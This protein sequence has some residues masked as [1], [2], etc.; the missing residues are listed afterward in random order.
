MMRSGK[1]SPD[2][3]RRLVLGKL[4]TRRAD[5]L[6][7][8]ALGEDSAVIDFG[9]ESCVLSADPITA[10]GERA[11]W[12]GVHVACN[13]IAAMGAAPVG[14]LA[15]VLLPES[16]DE[17]LVS[18]VMND[19]HRAATELGI[20]ILGGHTEVT[21]GIAAPILAMTAVGKAP[22]DRIVRSSG[23]RVG[24]AIVLAKWAGLEGT[25]ILSN[26]C[27]DDLTGRV[28]PALIAAGARC[29]DF[30][31][32]VRE[33]LAAAALGATAMHDPTEGGVLGAMW[34]MAES[35]GLGFELD[36]ERV[37]IREETQAICE[38]FGADPLKLISSGA[39]LIACSDGPA[40]VEGLQA[41]SLT[42]TVIGRM[43]GA[44]RVVLCGGCRE[45]AEPVWRD[46][47]WRVL[48]ERSG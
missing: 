21:P 26:D 31:S 25:A 13:D 14:V 23:A 32:V 38:V 37:P 11:G 3:L 24:D 35:S 34:E 16:A 22:R 8:A 10:A 46:E 48:D 4:G 5:V 43:Q 6:V 1:L 33:G 19:M 15:T 9:A 42:A 30:V 28:A 7:H 29:I 2:D 20:E 41:Q 47:L 40:M 39:L 27:A 18:A 44:E 36:A 12:L 45:P 17:A